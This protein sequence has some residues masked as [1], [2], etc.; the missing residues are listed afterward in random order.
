MNNAQTPS[1]LTASLR[2]QGRPPSLLRAVAEVSGRDPELQERRSTPKGRAVPLLLK[3][4][5]KEK[6]H[7]YRWGSEQKS[8]LKQPVQE[9]KGLNLPHPEAPASQIS[10]QAAAGPRDPRPS[11]IPSPAQCSP[12]TCSGWMVA[13]RRT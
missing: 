1:K 5:Q 4:G 8:V 7:V 3:P 2:L 11:S 13:W 12:P 10:P 9:Q 6:Q